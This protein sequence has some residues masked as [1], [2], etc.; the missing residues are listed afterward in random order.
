M[1]KIE[2]RPIAGNSGIYGFGRQDHDCTSVRRGGLAALILGPDIYLDQWVTLFDML[3][4]DLAFAPGCI[5]KHVGKP[6]LGSNALQD[7]GIAHPVRHQR[8]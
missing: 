4:A 5:V 2:S 6:Q 1:P 7:S 3:A 8:A